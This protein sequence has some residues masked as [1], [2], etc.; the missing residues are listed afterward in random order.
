MIKFRFK[1]VKE[2]T[3]INFMGVH[4]LALCLSGLMMV[5]SIVLLFTRG[6]N[7]GIDFTGGLLMEV[8]TPAGMSVGDIRSKLDSLPTGHPTIQE[9]GATEVLIKIPGREIDGA[10]Q[11]SLRAEVEQRLGVSDDQVRR[12]EY[13]GPQVGKE[14]IITGVKAFTYSMIGIML[15]IWMRYEWQFGATAVVSLAHDVCAT[16]LFFILTRIEFDLATVAAVLLVAGY[17]IN[18]TVVVF[19][20]IREE[21]KRYRKMPLDQL[22]NLA[23]NETLSR[24]LMT[25]L[26]TLVALAALAIFGSEVIKGFTYALLVGIVIGTYSSVFIAAPLLLHMNL[27]PNQQPAASGTA[28]DEIEG[29]KGKKSR[30]AQKKTEAGVIESEA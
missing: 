24:T 27:R 18:D 4:K 25:S 29:P 5:A 2:K 10:G 20:R 19:D 12:M 26:M 17:S 21:L 3:D 14:L 23:V 8:S 7:V 1:L 28:A 30:K 11:K 13:V 22:F 15:F 16:L 6:L 9:F